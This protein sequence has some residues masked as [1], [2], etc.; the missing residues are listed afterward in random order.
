MT[1][2]LEEICSLPTAPFLEGAVV[3]YVERFVAERKKLRLAR[4][5]HGN[6]LISLAG[7]SKAVARWVFTAHMD[8]PGLISG[9]M[10]DEQTVECELRGWVLAELMKGAKVRFFAG[11]REIRGEIVDVTA[12]GDEG[13]GAR[14]K[15]ARVRVG[16][17]VPANV[18]GVF[19]QGT[20]RIRNGKFYSRVCDDLAGAA[21]AMA[22]M[23]E[24][25]GNPPQSGVAVLLTRAEE[26]GFI[27]AVAA[28]IEPRLL[29]KSDRLIAIEC[30]AAQPY[31][32]IG[33]G[34]I[35]RVGDRTS[36]FNSALT[37][38]L[39]QQAE[40]LAKEDESFKYQRQLMPG[41]TCE[42]TVYD[43]YGFHAASMCVALGN[44][45]NMDRKRRKIAA[46][47]I[48]VG[49]WTNMVKLFL[50]V[51][52]AGHTYT[53]THQALKERIEKRFENL[54]HLL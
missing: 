42:A 45:H 17:S 31:A 18:A 19:D 7:R 28:S 3:E 22:M 25:H 14:G 40:A 34:A 15:M 13:R 30:S 29:K 37:F 52:R 1:K 44:Y 23:D 36:I 41:G 12:D 54:R 6:L 39:T 38:F 8:H 48:D 33:G 51:A 26:E 46:E 10:I 21:G 2:I 11:E 50:A 43:V 5:E 49:D 53:G 20:G 24:L 47:Y 9:R 35:I 4:D 27:G 16:K 32:P